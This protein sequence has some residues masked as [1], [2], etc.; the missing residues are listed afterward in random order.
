MDNSTF[1]ENLQPI[2]QQEKEQSSIKHTTQYKT[3]KRHAIRN[4]EINFGN[5][6]PAHKEFLSNMD[7]MAPHS[8]KSSNDTLM[9][10]SRTKNFS[11]IEKKTFE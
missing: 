11:V 6:L 3:T 1:L 5:L 10:Y 7:I 4:E 8:K 2:L 9:P